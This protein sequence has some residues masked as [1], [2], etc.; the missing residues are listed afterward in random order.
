MTIFSWDNLLYLGVNLFRV[1]VVFRFLRAFLK[2]KPRSIAIELTAYAV[3]Y[4]INSAIY[5]FVPSFV[6]FLTANI[7]PILALTFLYKSKIYVKG[8]ATLFIYAVG[9][10]WDV[11]PYAI[12]NSL[13]IETIVITSG[14]VN[15]LLVFLTVL[16]F[17]HF[18]KFKGGMALSFT[19]AI[20]ITIIPIGSIVIGVLTMTVFNVATAIIA[21]ILLLINITVFFLCNVLGRAYEKE[22]EKAL[23]EQQSK[24]YANQLHL[25]EESQKALRFIKHD[26]ENH[27][28]QMKRLLIEEDYNKLSDYLENYSGYMKPERQYSNSGNKDIDSML[29]YKLKEIGEK[30]IEIETRINLPDG[31]FIGVFDLNII[32]G[33]LVD[34]A[35]EELKKCGKGRMAIE[36]KENK[37][38]LFIKVENTCNNELIIENGRILTSKGDSINHGLGLQSVKHTLDKY[39][40]TM[41]I[42]AKDNLVTVNALIYNSKFEEILLV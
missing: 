5:L 7:A 38:V 35:V 34:N 11:I 20:A 16:L 18:S 8:L 36:I 17:E 12:F 33:N 31:L 15:V 3:F 41:R 27:F 28:M 6:A 25:M 21:L 4:I 22:Q 42:N 10:F 29:N 32:I 9:F 37:G 23:L 24:A 1:Y 13:H 14:I 19:H 39:N 2:T 30:G 40:G 26:I